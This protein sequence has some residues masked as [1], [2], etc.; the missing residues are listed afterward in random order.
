[1]K[2]KNLILP[3]FLL[4]AV[5]C[6]KTKDN[7]SATPSESYLNTATG[8]TWNYH[9][10]DSSGTTPIASDYTITSTSRDTTISGKSYHI[11]DNS[12]GGFQYLNKTGTD[13]YQFDSL[14]AGF[15]VGVFERLYLKDSAYAGTSWNQTQNVTVSGIPFAIPVILT[16]SIAERDISRTVNSVNY[17]NVIHVTASISS[18]LIPSTSLSSSINSYYAPIYGLIESSTKISL[19]YSGL[20]ENVNVSLKLVNSVLK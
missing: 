16:Y 17:S 6:T 10:I 13:Y 18:P 19:N 4:F 20:V 2:I 11:Y 1:M 12:T 5:S 9:V 15:G 8:S 14:P 7:G 3:A